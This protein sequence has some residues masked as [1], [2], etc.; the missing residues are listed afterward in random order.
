MSKKHTLQYK[1]NGLT[2]DIKIKCLR[3]LGKNKKVNNVLNNIYHRPPT[4]HEHKYDLKAVSLPR[5]GFKKVTRFKIDFN[6]HLT[7]TQMIY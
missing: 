2:Y 3:G 6:Y 1:G 4:I 5:V 7:F